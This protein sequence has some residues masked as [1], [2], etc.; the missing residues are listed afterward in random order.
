MWANVGHGAVPQTNQHSLSSS[1]MFSVLPFC[2][3]SAGWAPPS[4]SNYC[5][6]WFHASKSRFLSSKRHV[7]VEAR[8][9]LSESERARLAQRKGEVNRK[10]QKESGIQ[11]S[12]RD[13][14]PFLPNIIS[15]RSLDTHSN[16]NSVNTA[17]VSQQG[18]PPVHPTSVNTAEVSLQGNPPVHPTSVNTAEVSQQGNPPVHPN[19][20]NTAEVSLQGN[21]PVYP[22][23]VNTAEVS[24]QGNPP[25]HPTSVN[26][27][28]VSQQGNPPV[29]PTSVNTAEVSQQGNPPVYPTSVNTAKVSQQGNPPVHPT[30]VNTAEVSQQDN[31]PVHVTL[32]HRRG[33]ERPTGLI[34]DQAS[35][36]NTSF[37]FIRHR[38]QHSN[39]GMSSDSQLLDRRKAAPGSSTL[40]TKPNAPSAGATV[41]DAGT[42]AAPVGNNSAPHYQGLSSSHSPVGTNSAP[43]YQGLSSSHSPVAT[44][45]APHYQGL[46]SS[47]S[48][49]GTNSAPHYQGLSSSH[50]PVGTNSAPH[51]QGLSS[52]HSPVGTNSVPRH[53][54]GLSSSHSPVAMRDHGPSALLATVLPAAPVTSEDSEGEGRKAPAVML[55][56]VPE[57]VFVVDNMEKAMHA[58]KV[59]MEFSTKD[60]TMSIKG[61]DPKYNPDKTRYFGCDTE[62]AFLDVKTQSPIGHGTVIC[63]SIYGGDDIN[64]NM[65]PLS[66]VLKDRLWV[67][68]WPDVKTDEKGHPIMIMGKVQLKE[69]SVLNAFKGFF[70]NNDIKKVWHNYG[71]DRHVMSNM[72]I[73]C[74]GF[75]S[76]TMHMARLLDASRRGRKNYSLENLTD[77]KEIM[78][79]L[80]PT[81]ALPPYNVQNIDTSALMPRISRQDVRLQLAEAAAAK[82]PLRSGSVLVPKVSMKTIF[83]RPAT[84]KDG[85]QGKLM[86]MPEIMDLHNKPEYRFT[87][88][89][90]SALDAKATWQLREA[91]YR[92]LKQWPWLV[93]NHLSDVM[94]LHKLHR[95]EPGKSAFNVASKFKAPPPPTLYEFYLSNWVDFGK[96]LTDMEAEGMMVNREHLRQAQVAAVAD[97][98]KA[99]KT[100]HEWAKT[101]VEMAKY[102]NVSSGA[103]IRALFYP[104]F[105]GNITAAA[106]SSKEAPRAS[107]A[108]TLADK[109]APRASG[110]NTLA[111]KEAPRASEANTLAD[112]EAPRASEANTL[113]DKEAPRASEANTLADKEATSPTQQLTSA[114]LDYSAEEEEDITSAAAKLK[115]REKAKQKK[116]KEDESAVQAGTR[117]FKVPNPHYEEELAQFQAWEI[118]AEEARA[119]KKREVAEEKVAKKR[120]KEELKELK[121]PEG[122][123]APAAAAADKLTIILQ[124]A[125]KVESISCGEMRAFSTSVVNASTSSSIGGVGNAGSHPSEVGFDGWREVGKG[126]SVTAAEAVSLGL[127]PKPSRPKKY[128]EMVL[129]GVWGKGVP[130]RLQPEEL[131]AT[132]A[133]PVS[134]R[135]LKGLAGKSGAAKKALE[136]LMKEKQ[137]KQ[138]ALTTMLLEPKVSILE[139]DFEEAAKKLFPEESEGL[140]EGVEDADEGGSSGDEE[141]DGRAKTAP[142]TSWVDYEA[143]DKEAKEKGFG[144][145]YSTFGGGEE[146]LKACVAVEALCEISAIDKLLSA[147]IIPLQSDDIS[148][149][150]ADG[151]HRIH[152]SLNINTETGRLS[153][154]RPNLQNQPALE[155]DRYKVRKAFCADISEDKTLIVADYGQLELRIL[156]HM[157]ACKSMITAFVLGGD[158]HSRTAYGMYDYIQEDVK[159]GEC[160]LEWEGE[161][162]P[163]KPVLKDKYAAERRKA[164][165]LNF[166]IAYGKTAHGLAKDFNTSLQE[167][168]ETVNKWYSDRK[169]VRKWQSDTRSNARIDKKV[170]PS[171]TP[172][173]STLLGRNRPLPDLV[174]QDRRKNGHAER[175]AINTPIQGSAA[176]VAASAMVAISRC[177]KL[178]DMGWKLLMQIHDEVILE[179]PKHN[180]EDARALV[181]AHMANPWKSIIDS[182]IAK[183]ARPEV[184][185][186]PDSIWKDDGTEL[187]APVEPLLVDLATDSNIADTWYEAK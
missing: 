14:L 177:D 124:S 165:I 35:P 138:D 67:D 85:T 99:V 185:F 162:A 184:L 88:I 179:G 139:D 158:F 19:S 102:M 26:T 170:A 76:D 78:C 160:I 43:H 10:K 47:H 98:E 114:M 24:L 105:A 23:S 42:V 61:R 34:A 7:L 174:S 50:S 128:I 12:Y 108:N 152:C 65:D 84:K 156:A 30:S 117:V 71:F 180:A 8:S 140:A 33:G 40:N 46:S 4:L 171:K 129:H 186:K 69:N 3:R 73:D 167:A 17:E 2:V 172:F 5:S 41:P 49:V 21:P 93:D 91:L 11:L 187:K 52:S 119:R 169:E 80:S 100:F 110:A 154:R 37:D 44:N 137:E 55:T 77:D 176:D 121:R 116:K 101:K 182:A 103:Q 56:D 63:F 175:A 25:V 82:P 130:G 166:S 59:L 136:Q 31:P 155:K 173:V 70:E 16:P 32:D 66:R 120:K 126:P 81:D 95:K 87:W 148:T 68:V 27:A 115:A 90:Y 151:R 75:A 107:E 45:S 64:F 13:Q 147:F 183:G 178:R 20:V 111:D 62:V 48:P 141:A 149:T 112:K 163:P 164:K 106:K 36:A 22:T 133:A 132:N 86:V 74:N 28:E 9:A 153:A 15:Q 18:N 144:K 181:V 168:E 94:A 38:D 54:Q 143:L 142:T 104:E 89:D 39:G 58:V 83:S 79:Y 145:L 51:Y 131:T 96:V 97:R 150:D 157:A 92:Q 135:V 159:K 1:A 127:P 161:G 29:H 109:E 146:G 122:E 113:A 118:L 6:S 125:A 53:Y 72:G 60:S 134:I 123:T 57:D